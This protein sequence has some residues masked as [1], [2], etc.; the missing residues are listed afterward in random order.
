MRVENKLES[1]GLPQPLRVEF[2]SLLSA[3]HTLC[4]DADPTKLSN[5][6]GIST[7]DI[8]SVIEGGYTLA[9]QLYS[10]LVRWIGK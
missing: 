8:G 6:L 1:I 10:Y 2:M 7:E 5:L 3:V 9:E 4:S